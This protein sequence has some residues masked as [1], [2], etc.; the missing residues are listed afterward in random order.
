M[1]RMKF[2]LLL[3]FVLVFSGVV[4]AVEFSIG[5]SPNVVDVGEI[6]PGE[7]KLVKFSIFTVSDEPLLVYLESENGNMDF[8]NIGYKD[9]MPQFSEENILPWVEFL[10]NPVEILIHG[11]GAGRSWTDINLVI[12]V[13]E[14]AEPG[15]HVFYVQ[16]KPTVYGEGPG[17]PIGATIVSVA[18][19]SVIFKVAGDSKRDGIIL[20]TTSHGYSDRGFTIKTYFQNTGTTTLYSRAVNKIYDGNNFVGEFSSSREYVSPGEVMVFQTPVYTYLDEGE[21][22]IVSTVTYTTGDAQQ[23][24]TINLLKPIITA[25]AAEER[26]PLD[27]TLI[28]IVI[29]AIVVIIVAIRWLRG[30]SV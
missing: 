3:L 5:V 17:A 10:S 2:A 12:S 26:N 16:P 29:I 27:I 24:T 9:R 7:Q 21:Y 14:D 19:V 15:Y 1:V 30:G 6:Q 13:P 20:D 25:K 11:D 28:L 18:K 22:N 8:F 4:H 23:E